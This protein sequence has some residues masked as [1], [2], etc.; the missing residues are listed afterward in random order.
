MSTEPK[1]RVQ[2]GEILASNGFAL[3]LTE[4]KLIGLTPSTGDSSF[5]TSKPEFQLK[6]NERWVLEKINFK[7]SCS[8]GSI[9][10]F[11]EATS[12]KYYVQIKTQAGDKYFLELSNLNFHKLRKDA[13]LHEEKKDSFIDR[14]YDYHQ[15]ELMVNKFEN[16]WKELSG[17]KPI[18]SS[19]YDAIHLDMIA[20]LKERLQSLPEGSKVRLIEIGCGRGEL[21]K[22]ALSDPEIAPFVSRIVLLDLFPE[23]IAVARNNAETARP[24]VSCSTI[25]QGMPDGIRSIEDRTEDE[26]TMVLSSGSLTHQVLT[27]EQALKTMELL[28]EKT[29]E[30]IVGGYTNSWINKKAAKQLGFSTDQ[31]PKITQQT[32]TFPPIDETGDYK[33]DYTPEEVVKLT[34]KKVENKATD[35]ISVFKRVDITPKL[36]EEISTRPKALERY[37]DLKAKFSRVNSESNEED[38]PKFG[39][40]PKT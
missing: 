14:S 11:S 29:D 18:V 30:L 27:R 21:M 12:E 10:F 32:Y 5:Y 3:D 2:L 7:K 16:Y 38:E 22:K 15:T 35:L 40:S 17:Y 23:N 19:S 4:S 36:A 37:F 8:I 39:P 9:H 26:Y 25:A 34:V 28:H 20:K 1:E 24:D 6:D 33:T 13:Y 31:Q